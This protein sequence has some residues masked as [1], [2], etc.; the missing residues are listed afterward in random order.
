MHTQWSRARE[1]RRR[2]TDA[3]RTLWRCLRF[4]QLGGFKFRRQSPIGPFIADFVCIERRL[5]IEVDGG[6][7]ADQV[8]RDERRTEY[9]RTRGYHVL[10]FWDHDVLLQTQDVVDSIFHHLQGT[11]PQPSPATQGRG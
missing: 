6:Q 11:P 7:H 4:R 9:L 3:E 10:R 8:E 5:V 2:L 1:L